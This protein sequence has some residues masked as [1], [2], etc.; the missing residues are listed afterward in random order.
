MTIY[1]SSSQPFKSRDLIKACKL[2][3]KY[4]F[5]SPAANKYFHFRVNEYGD[6]VSVTFK[7]IVI[8]MASDSEGQK[9]KMVRE[10]FNRFNMISFRCEGRD[11]NGVLEGIT[12]DSEPDSFVKR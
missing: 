3:S 7:Q 8:N 10:L 4:G 6:N 2:L 11:K 1:L 5:K 9:D 12:L